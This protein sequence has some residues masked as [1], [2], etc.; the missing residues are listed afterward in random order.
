MCTRLREVRRAGEC[1]PRSGAQGRLELLKLLA[2]S[3]AVVLA[4][5]TPPIQYSE[6]QSQ[7]LDGGGN[8]EFDVPFDLIISGEFDVPL[9][10][11]AGSGSDA[12]IDAPDDADAGSDADAAIDAPDDADAGSDADAAIDAPDDAGSGSDAAIPDAGIP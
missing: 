4:A 11:D 8:G 5:C 12:A 3:I 6:V 1:I 10:P 9:P 2:T 7:L